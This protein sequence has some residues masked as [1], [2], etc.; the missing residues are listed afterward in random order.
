M[1]ARFANVS[2][3]G[4]GV[5][6]ELQP[7]ELADVNGGGINDPIAAVGVGLGHRPPSPPPSPPPEPRPP[8]WE[9]GPHY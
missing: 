4:G 5:L 8:L 3:E 7:S 1:N 6:R 2:S 9:I